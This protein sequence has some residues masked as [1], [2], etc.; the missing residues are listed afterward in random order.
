MRLILAT[1]SAAEADDLAVTLLRERLIACSN[2]VPGVRSHYWWEG[3]LCCDEEV[4][5]LMETSAAGAERAARRLRELH[6]YD[7]PKILTLDPS[8]CDPAYRDWLAAVLEPS[9]V[10]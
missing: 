9:A 5:L 8:A 6:S 10:G 1:C 7:V 3:E 2:V 4:L